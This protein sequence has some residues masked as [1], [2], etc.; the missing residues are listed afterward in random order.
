MGMRNAIF[1]RSLVTFAKLAPKPALDPR[2]PLPAN[3]E[4]PIFDPFFAKLIVW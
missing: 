3:D 1:G 2:G 4:E